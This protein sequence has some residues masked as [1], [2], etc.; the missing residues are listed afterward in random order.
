MIKAEEAKALIEKE[1]IEIYLQLQQGMDVS[2]GQRLR[3]EGKV[4]MLLHWQLIDWQWLKDFINEQYQGHFNQE[5]F[6]D[7]WVWM[8][9][10]KRFYLPVKMRDAPVFRG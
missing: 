6:H 9:D 8:Q 10:D 7:H 5:L 4:E 2:V 3:L 1:V